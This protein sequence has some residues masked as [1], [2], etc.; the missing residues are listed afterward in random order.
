MLLNQTRM[1]NSFVPTTATTLTSGTTLFKYIVKEKSKSVIVISSDEEG[2]DDDQTKATYSNSIEELAPK[3]RKRKAIKRKR[4]SLKAGNVNDPISLSDSEE[5]KENNE[6]IASP[7][8][9]EIDMF[10]DTNNCYDDDEI[11][12]NPINSISEQ[13]TTTTEEQQQSSSSSS[14][15]S[16]SK[17]ENNL[18]LNFENAHQ[19]EK[20]LLLSELNTVEEQQLYNKQLEDDKMK[21]LEGKTINIELAAADNKEQQ[22]EEQ[23]QQQQVEDDDMSSLSDMMDLDTLSDI[24]NTDLDLSIPNNNN[25]KVLSS[26]LSSVMSDISLKKEE[27]SDSMDIDDLVSS[28]K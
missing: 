23:Q 5:E 10:A 4:D 6:I 3:P 13:Y 11:I 25:N 1:D 15:S 12:F 19:N 18:N 22:V 2:S 9:E 7:T 27:R 16:S 8:Q 17:N 28:K 21:E 20:K 24:A 26:P 14:S